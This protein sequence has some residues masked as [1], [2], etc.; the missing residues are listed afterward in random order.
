MD[1]KKLSE[2]RLNYKI[3][4]IK[5]LEWLKNTAKW[6][7]YMRCANLDE[8]DI[9]FAN[10]THYETLLKILTQ[11]FNAN[12]PW[13]T[14]FD[15]NNEDVPDIIV[16]KL[17]FVTECNGG[18]LLAVHKTTNEIAAFHVRIDVC[19]LNYASMHY[20][21]QMNNDD[22]NISYI[23]ELIGKLY[24]DFNPNVEQY[25]KYNW[26]GMSFVSK[27][28]QMKGLMFA[29]VACHNIIL[30]ELGYID[31]YGEATHIRMR[32]IGK[33]MGSITIKSI[34]WKNFVFSDGKHMKYFL[35]KL[36]D[37][38]NGDQVYVNKILKNCSMELLM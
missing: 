32:N 37:K 30:T 19:D 2:I 35:K 16:S 18:A 3:Q 21:K 29:L 4:K 11:N 25:G 10:K 14:L 9:V 8:F 31:S 5:K 28:Y 24:E 22:S 7:E 38:Y 6:K 15:L 34:D 26:G 13:I 23:G 27:P 36:N 1:A 20:Y 12:N 33:Y 17:K